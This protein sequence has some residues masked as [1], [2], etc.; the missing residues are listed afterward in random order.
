[1]PLSN[2]A[3]WA[4]TR[5]EI[6]SQALRKVNAIGTGE[7]A[8]SSLVSETAASLNNVVKALHA[9][10]MPL[11]RISE[12]QITPVAG[13]ASYTIGESGAAVTDKAPLKIIQAFRRTGSGT[14]QADT[15]LKI[16]SQYDYNLIANKG[17]QGSPSELSYREPGANVATAALGT[18]YLWPVPDTNFVTTN[19]GKIVIVYQRPFDDLDA[20]ADHL[21]FPPHFYQAIVW[22]LA[23]EIARENGVPLA[24]GSIIHKRAQEEMARA[25]AFGTEEG[26]LKFVPDPN[27][28]LSLQ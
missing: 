10:G 14:T 12:L 20:A 19:S 26:S 22:A 16:L 27:Y 4:R 1:M 13:T 5:D 3:N 2:S 15:P 21:D 7:T 17:A 6:I 11:W 23:D 8:D 28:L 25:L 18:I 9:E 24:E